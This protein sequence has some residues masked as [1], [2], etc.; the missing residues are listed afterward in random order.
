MA[1]YKIDLVFTDPYIGSRNGGDRTLESGLSLADAKKRLLEIFNEKSGVYATTWAE[2]KRKTV[3]LLDNATSTGKTA[4]FDY[5]GRMFV[6]RE[7]LKAYEV[8][9]DV[10]GGSRIVFVAANSVNEIRECNGILR[11]WRRT[12]MTADDCSYCVVSK[13]ITAKEE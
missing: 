12:D 11:I 2:A 10:P 8:R 9:I 1:T 4:R 3:K 5:D 6:I 13:K 7:E